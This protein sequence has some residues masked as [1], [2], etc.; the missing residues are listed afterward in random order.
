MKLEDYVKLTKGINAGKDID[1]DFIRTI[2]ETI[3]TDPIT[4][5]EDDEARLR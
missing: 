3:E 2:Y 4:L 1:S 5:I